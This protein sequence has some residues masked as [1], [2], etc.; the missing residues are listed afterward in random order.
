MFLALGAGAWSQAIFHLMTHAFFKALLFL[1]SGAVILACHH[2]QDIFKMGGLR[3]KLPLAFWCFVVGGGA[4]AAVPFLTAG[5]FS[6]D[7]ILWQAYGSGHINLFWAGLAGAFL[8]SLYTSRLILVVFFGEAKTEAHQGHGVSYWLP[9]SV[10]LVLST[11]IGALIH[12]PLAG[13]LPESGAADDGGSIQHMIEALSGLVAVSGILLG[14]WLF[15]GQPGLMRWVARDPLCNLL[16]RYWFSA[17][18]FDWLYDRL[19]VKPFLWLVKVNARDL[20]D[21]ILG[22][23]PVLLRSLNKLTALSESGRLRWYSASMALGAV[24]VIAAVVY[25]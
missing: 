16:R 5:F 23:I 19:F 10:L 3:K 11:A 17:F 2:E 18:G 24:V 22:S 7:Q 1:A 20:F 14:I 15:Y 13:V 4:L 6:K 9:L 21:V 12:P 8:T 25:L